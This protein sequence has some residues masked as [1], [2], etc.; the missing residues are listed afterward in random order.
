M[1]SLIE[2]GWYTKAGEP[3]V[4]SAFRAPFEGVVKMISNQNA[5]L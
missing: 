5:E 1:L 2:K 4:K 3:P